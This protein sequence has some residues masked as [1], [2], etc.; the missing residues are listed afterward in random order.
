[1]APVQQSTIV[2]VRLGF[3]VEIAD[4]AGQRRPRAAAAPARTKAAEDAV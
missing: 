1:M 3:G 4:H 2:A